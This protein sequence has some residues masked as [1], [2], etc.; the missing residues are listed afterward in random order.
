MGQK[1]L[2][3]AI[4]KGEEGE[5]RSSRLIVPTDDGEEETH[6]VDPIEEGSDEEEAQIEKPE[7]NEGI[8]EDIDGARG[9]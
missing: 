5:Y 7:I 6:H 9:F 8:D 3:E 4:E 2:G 1:G